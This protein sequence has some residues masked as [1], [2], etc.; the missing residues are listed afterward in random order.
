MKFRVGRKKGDT[1]VE[2]MF[3][4]GIFS[5]VAI[6]ITSVLMSGS[7][8]MQT[9]LE[10]T[11]ARNEIDAQAEALRFIHQGYIAEKSDEMSGPYTSLWNQIVNLAKSNDAALA[12]NSANVVEFRPST[13][14]VLYDENAENGLKKLNAFAIDTQNIGSENAVKKYGLSNEGNFVESSLYPRL[15]YSN[16]DYDGALLARSTIL[17][18][19]E[20]LFIVGVRDQDTTSVVKDDEQLNGST[21]F[22]DFYIRSCWYGYGKKTPTTISTLIRLYDPDVEIENHNTMD[23]VLSFDWSGHDCGKVNSSSME[24]CPVKKIRKAVPYNEAFPATTIDNVPAEGYFSYEEPL[25]WSLRSDAKCGESDVLKKGDII[26][27]FRNTAGAHPF[28]TYYAVWE[29]KYWISYEKNQKTS[30]TGTV[31]FNPTSEPGYS[32][33]TSGSTYKFIYTRTPDANGDVTISLINTQPSATSATFAGW[34]CRTNCAGEDISSPLRQPG[35][36]VTFHR[37]EQTRVYRANWDTIPKYTYSLSFN[38]NG[39]SGSGFGTQSFGPSTD[40]SHQFTIPSGKPTKSSYTFKGWATSNGGS[41]AYA[42]GSK[43]TLNS[44]STSMTLYAVWSNTSF[45]SGTSASSCTMMTL[46][47]RWESGDLDGVLVAVKPNAFRIIMDPNGIVINDTGAV[48]GPYFIS[49]S[50]RSSVLDTSTNM[51]W[52]LDCHG[53]CNDTTGQGV[54]WGNAGVLG[55]TMSVPICRGWT[56][57]YHVKNRNSNTL[58]RYRAGLTFGYQYNGGDVYFTVTPSTSDP[59]RYNNADWIPFKVETDHVGSMRSDTMCYPGQDCINYRAGE[60]Y[61]P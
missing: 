47:L 27:D 2:V 6:T 38:L 15:F 19:I 49:T 22:Y 51:S 36:S 4:I 37:N 46:F 12:R 9:S 5:L 16:T 13:C 40:T 17:R 42:A 3:A 45:A 44:S 31:S 50:G 35:S 10:T 53:A 32:S 29:C 7:S 54:D 1:L 30:E 52:S 20:G 8:N 34:R 55:E 60:W 39:G 33:V 24:P 18:G 25:G 48:G 14:S 58:V 43:V 59:N 26:S 11:M 41:V 56:Y 57:E 23:F 21:A 28:R 61:K